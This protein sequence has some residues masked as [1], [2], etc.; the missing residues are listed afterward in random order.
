[1]PVHELFDRVRAQAFSQYHH[2]VT[3][4]SLSCLSRSDPSER[5]ERR[6]QGNPASSTPWILKKYTTPMASRAMPSELH[7]LETQMR[8]IYSTV[9]LA[10]LILTHPSFA[11]ITNYTNKQSWQNAVQKSFVT[12]DFTGYPHLTPLNNQYE[13][14]GVL[15]TD[16]DDRFRQH[17]GFLNDGH[18]MFANYWSSI[19]EFAE[20]Q[21]AFAVEH[22]ASTRFELF[23]HGASIGLSQQFIQAGFFH[24]SGITSTQP[25]DKIRIYNPLGDDTNVD[26]MHFSTVPG[27]GTIPVF[28]VL[29]LKQRRRR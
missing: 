5:P 27:A 9:A 2:W 19:I 12:I 10:F 22:L 15:F 26:D 7:L 1:M 23:Y 24:F 29:L 25:F 20:P 4:P 14:I 28:G 18:G 8:L 16:G 11:T 21:Y 13:S 17:S 6:S 3:V